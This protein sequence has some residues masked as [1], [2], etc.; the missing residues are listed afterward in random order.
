MSW[1]TYM[2]TITVPVG[3]ELIE[4]QYTGLPTI[5]ATRYE[6]GQEA[7]IEKAWAADP[8]M[9]ALIEHFGL[10]D[11]IAELIGEQIQEDAD[12]AALDSAIADYEE[13]V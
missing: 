12:N 3:N 5:P 2:Q 9:Q 13:A 4:F 7:Q 10:A 6:Q 1:V 8:K 11:S